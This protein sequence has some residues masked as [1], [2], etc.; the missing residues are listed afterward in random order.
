MESKDFTEEIRDFNRRPEV[1]EFKRMLDPT[2][3][4]QKICIP[5]ENANV[6]LFY[7]EAEGKRTWEKQIRIPRKQD[8]NSNSNGAIT[9]MEQ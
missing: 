8:V 6:F 9:T 3:P 1:M 2:Y 4:H 7:S 5:F